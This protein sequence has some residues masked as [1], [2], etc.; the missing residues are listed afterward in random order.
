MRDRKMASQLAKR[1]F[2]LWQEGRLEEAVECY[3]EALSCADPDFYATPEYQGE[4][5]HVLAALHRDGEARAAYEKYLETLLRR[6]DSANDLE[7]AVA[8]Y[9]LG[10]H[11]LDM[12]H[13]TEAL[14]VVEPSLQRH[15]PN[16]R[17]G[18]LRVVRVQA[19]WSLGRRDGRGKR[20]RRPWQSN[21]R[22]RDVTASARRYETFFKSRNN[23]SKWGRCRNWRDVTP[24]PWIA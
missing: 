22:K 5:A 8:R 24:K 15:H 3:R 19:L 17:L 21:R 7:I 18:L 16:D 2:D 20:H 23:Q 4:L 10:Q 1:G 12:S 13:A 11:R 14:A 6:P 9:F